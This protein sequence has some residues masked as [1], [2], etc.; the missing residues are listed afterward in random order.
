[1]SYAPDRESLRGRDAVVVVDARK[2]DRE[3]RDLLESRFKVLEEAGSLEIPVGRAPFLDVEPL[4]FVF[5]I[6]RD[7]CPEPSMGRSP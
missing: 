7:Y 2:R 6:A 3:Y 4:R 1:M 5:Y